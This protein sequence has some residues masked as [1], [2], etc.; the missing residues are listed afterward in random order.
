[1]AHRRQEHH[2]TRLGTPH[3]RR[4]VRDLGHPYGIAAWVEV[5]EHG[6]GGVQLVAQDEYEIS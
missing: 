2:D 6:G 5:I 3:L 4:L 1:M